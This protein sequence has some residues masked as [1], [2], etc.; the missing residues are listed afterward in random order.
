MHVVFEAG[1][2]KIFSHIKYMGNVGRG[3]RQLQLDYLLEMCLHISYVD[4][5][6]LKAR[7]RCQLVILFSV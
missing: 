2:Y 1:A 7:V 3:L 4:G 5:I 6:A